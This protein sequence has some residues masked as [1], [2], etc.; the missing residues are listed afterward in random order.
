MV[1]T[2]KH[3]KSK[4]AKL[5]IRKKGGKKSMKRVGRKAAKKTMKKRKGGNNRKLTNEETEKEYKIIKSEC[6]IHGN[7]K[8]ECISKSKRLYNNLCSRL[9]YYQTVKNSLGKKTY[10]PKY[11]YDTTSERCKTLAETAETGS[12][13]E[14]QN[15]QNNDL[16]SN[17]GE[18]ETPAEIRLG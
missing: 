9:D 14:S 16:D 18:D 17:H 7:Q 15:K 6:D 11:L 2:R 12:Y 1:H 3:L 4:K 5:S 13:Q 10:I 8:Y